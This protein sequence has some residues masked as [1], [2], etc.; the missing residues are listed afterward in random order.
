M[1]S[2]ITR[3]FRRLFD[4]LPLAIQNDAK[5]AYRL[6]KR[7]PYHNSLQFKEIKGQNG[8]Y[9]VRIGL[10]WRAIATKDDDEV[11]WFWIGSHADYDKL[12][13]RL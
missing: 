7:D 12:L 13:T 2:H 5:A 11:T 1:N 6:W 4:A 10:H 8:V 9:S 3:N